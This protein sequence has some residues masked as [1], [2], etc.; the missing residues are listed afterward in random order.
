VAEPAFF[1]FLVERLALQHRADHLFIDV[2]SGKGRVMMLAALAGFRRVIGLEFAAGLAQIARRNI[3][4][5][6]R[7]FRHADFTVVDG[8]A[9][10]FN[11]PAVPTVLFLNNPFDGELIGKLLD[12]IERAHAGSTAEVALL[13][14]HSVHADLI[15]VRDGWEEI[16][17]G[18]FRSRRQFYAIFR[19]R[20]GGQR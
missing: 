1:N 8:D 17:R 7:Q 16:D 2:G 4:I 12:S 13:Y 6:S 20:M 11:F 14:M 3:V 5:F 9:T 15:R 10:R 18:C 19:R